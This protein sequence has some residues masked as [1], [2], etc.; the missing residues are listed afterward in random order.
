MYTKGTD[1][2]KQKQTYKYRTCP[3]VVADLCGSFKTK[4]ILSFHNHYQSSLESCLSYSC[5][6]YMD[7]QMENQITL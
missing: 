5:C 6:V 2:S 1:A 4:V 3:L 7:R